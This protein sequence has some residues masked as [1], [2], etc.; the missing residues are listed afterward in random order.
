MAPLKLTAVD[1][2]VFGLVLLAPSEVLALIAEYVEVSRCSGST[3]A[4]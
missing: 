2:D 4:V 3:Y 1:I